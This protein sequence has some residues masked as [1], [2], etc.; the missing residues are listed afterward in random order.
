MMTTTVTT[1]DQKRSITYL[2][3]VNLRF[4]ILFNYFFSLF[5]LLEIYSTTPMENLL[6]AYCQNNHNILLQI[7]YIQCQNNMNDVLD[8][9]HKIHVIAFFVLFLN[10]QFIFIMATF[11]DCIVLII[12]SIRFY[13]PNQ[14]TWLN[15][16]LPF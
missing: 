2:L 3:S 9:F 10:R 12:T 1:S 13:Y 4:Q 11:P 15:F 7:K 14:L 6:Q 16:V 5:G 8:R